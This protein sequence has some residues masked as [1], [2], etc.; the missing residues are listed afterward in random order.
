MRVPT[1]TQSKKVHQSER[2]SC[3]SPS[4]VFAARNLQRVRHRGV[5]LLPMALQ[6]N[7]RS[8]QTPNP[9]SLV[10]QSHF[11]RPRTYSI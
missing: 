7:P 3:P 4:L 6:G 5:H 1:D 11:C 8:S 10:S 2:A 9:L